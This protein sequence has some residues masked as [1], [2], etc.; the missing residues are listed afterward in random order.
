MKETKVLTE[1]YDKEEYRFLEGYQ[2]WGG[3]SMLRK[4]LK[5]KPGDIVEMVKASGLRGRGGAGFPTGVKWGFLPKN[6]EPR[7]LLCN[8]DEG[9][10]GTFKDRL[11]MER[12]PHQLIEGMLIAAYAIE[13]HKSY[14]YVRGEYNYPIRVLEKALEEAYQAGLLG[15]NILG[16]GFH[17]DM[18]IYRGAGAYIC[19]EETGLIS[20]LE[21][22]KGQPKLK[23]PFPAVQGYLKKP[24]IV[25]N[26]ETL[27]AVVIILRDGPEGYR[28]YGTEK[29][30]GTK[31]FS[32]SGNVL[33]P[34]N[35]EVPLGFPLKDLIFGLGGGIPN[36]HQLK[37]VIP[38]GSS[39]PVLTAEEAM[40]ATLDYECLANMGT[41]LGSGAVIVLDDRQCMVDCLGNLMHFYHHESCG[42]CTPCREGTGWL[43][44][45]TQRILSG[46]GQPADV[47][48]LFKVADNMKGRTIC[49]L[50]DAAALPV[51]SFV[52]KFRDEFDYYVHNGKSKVKGKV[53]AHA[54]MYH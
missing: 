39:A 38:G 32:L 5:M 45:I 36:G 18:D 6:G 48:L 17:H 22:Y 44:K 19:G 13:S 1:H 28:K 50:S 37:A 14:I 40:R 49:A 12:A 9:E 34:G 4:A 27:A 8:A 24:T 20:S 21:G 26:V 15:R 35:Y 43:D 11:I 30:P 42:Q 54:Q 2:K 29:S 10:P 23:P 41:M 31:I 46:Q 7:Y 51:M 53:L 3:Y 52:T 25:N 16:S 33:R 47:D